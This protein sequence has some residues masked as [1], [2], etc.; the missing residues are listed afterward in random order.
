MASVYLDGQPVWLQL[1]PYT[2]WEMAEASETTV[3]SLLLHA[4]VSSRATARKLEVL[5]Y[6]LLRGTYASESIVRTFLHPISL[7]GSAMLNTYKSSHRLLR[8][9]PATKSSMSYLRS[10][11]Y[12]TA[13][14]IA[15]PN[16]YP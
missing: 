4:Q 6:S 10:L 9:I 8:I 2:M 13:F 11:S 12:P 15:I 16:V 1:V 7:G 14:I 3:E 5:L